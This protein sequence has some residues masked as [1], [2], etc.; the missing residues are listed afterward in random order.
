MEKERLDK[1]SALVLNA[2]QEQHTPRSL[3]REPT[4]DLTLAAAN[5]T[6]RK[7]NFESE[8]TNTLGAPEKRNDRLG[9]KTQENDE[10]E[11]IEN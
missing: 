6:T 4:E 5:A 1:V 8:L 2:R 7:N 3:R 11:P 10:N 9:I